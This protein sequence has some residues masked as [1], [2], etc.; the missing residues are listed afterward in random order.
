M[1]TEQRL[2]ERQRKTKPLLKSRESWLRVKVKILSRHSKLTKAFSYTLN[3][4]PALTYYADDGWTEADNNIAENA[5]RTISL[6]RKNSCSSALTMVVSG[7]HSCTAWSERANWTAW[8][9]KATSAMCLKPSPTGQS[10]GSAKCYPGASHCQ[11]N[12]ASRQY[13]SL[14]TLTD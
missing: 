2:A 14:C 11:L 9:Q 5:L 8:I 10:T 4:W 3:Q 1:S 7:G 12:N 13:G 6:G